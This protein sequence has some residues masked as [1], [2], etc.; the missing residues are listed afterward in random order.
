MNTTALSA[1]CLAIAAGQNA[2]FSSS[3][4]ARSLTAVVAPGCGSSP[5][6]VGVSA[7]LL[8]LSAIALSSST[9]NKTSFSVDG[10]VDVVNVNLR[11]KGKDDVVEDSDTV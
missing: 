7:L 8:L 3:I 1:L 5:V 11:D 4:D 9:S 10:E 2:K 6:M